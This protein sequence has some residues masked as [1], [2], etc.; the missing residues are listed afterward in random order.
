MQSQQSQQFLQTGT[1]AGQYQHASGAPA[2]NRVSSASGVLAY[3][4]GVPLAFAFIAT[5]GRA[6]GGVLTTLL[7]DV[8]IDLYSHGFNI[9]SIFGVG[10]AYVYFQIPMMIML[11]KIA[12]I[13]PA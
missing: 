6:P 1:A 7:K 4:A 12:P 10:L 11:R 3:F 8:G 2:R 5:L 9:S 13:N